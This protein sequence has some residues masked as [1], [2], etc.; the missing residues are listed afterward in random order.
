MH[1]AV[2]SDSRNAPDK[3]ACRPERFRGAVLRLGSLASVRAL[4]RSAEPVRRTVSA[5]CTRSSSG[6]QRRARRPG[7]NSTGGQPESLRVVP[8][9]PEAFHSAP[10]ARDALAE[11]LYRVGIDARCRYSWRVR[12]VAWPLSGPSPRAARE[13]GTTRCGYPV[14]VATSVTSPRAW[15][16]QIPAPDARICRAPAR[17]SDGGQGHFGAL[18]CPAGWWQFPP[19]G[20]GAARDSRERA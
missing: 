15:R 17:Q 20:A 16:R 7:P 8:L 5:H 9:P 11:R 2:R 3:A 4:L 18:L 12:W 1:V 13:R 14:R 19:P 10:V 6:G